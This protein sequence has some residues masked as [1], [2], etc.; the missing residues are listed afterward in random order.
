MTVSSVNQPLIV[1]S[2]LPADFARIGDEVVELC[3]AGVDRISVG[4]DPQQPCAQLIIYDW[5]VAE[6]V[7]GRQGKESRHRCRFQPVARFAAGDVA[8]VSH[9]ASPHERLQQRK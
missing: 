8:L 7:R 3:E 1:P 6:R 4:A 9:G 5:L 2:V